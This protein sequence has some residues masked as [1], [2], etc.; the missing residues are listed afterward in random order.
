M[1]TNPIDIVVASDA[2]YLPGLL[3]TLGTAAAF[4]HADHEIHV[5]VLDSGL[6]DT[7]WTFLTDRLA[8]FTNLRIERITVGHERF[9][10][11]GPGIG[12]N[13]GSY[14]RLLIPELLTAQR[15]I[16]M[17]VDFLVF[18]DLS[19]LFEIDLDGHPIGAVADEFTPSMAWDWKKC[20]EGVLFEET[21][22][23]SGLLVID[24]EAWRKL[25]ITRQ[26]I[27][28]LKKY[29]PLTHFHDQS[30]INTLCKNATHSLEG[31]WNRHYMVTFLSQFGGDV[32]DKCIH[33][34]GP[35]PW[36]AYDPGL[37]AALWY[38]CYELLTGEA[39]AVAS[40]GLSESRVAVER[41]LGRALRKRLLYQL[42]GQH[43]RF[44]IHNART[45]ESR[46][47]PEMLACIQRQLEYRILGRKRK[48]A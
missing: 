44:C 31:D 22:F 1:L 42:T 8:R 27:D 9:D 19:P 47:D 4:C 43:K 7:D 28:F 46:Y 32:F 17:D 13:H 38:T 15:V 30:A 21:Y 34:T 41:Q 35:V 25:D 20:P 48:Q 10:Q 37:P 16:Y 33:L 2:N 14:C 45:I 26:A 40:L 6:S 12:G 39:D 3:V 11:L 23:N 36:K 29:K 5:T 24:T 18:R